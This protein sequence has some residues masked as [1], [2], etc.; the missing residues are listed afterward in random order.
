MPS[1]LEKKESKKRLIV[2]L[3]FCPLEPVKVGKSRDSRMQLLNS[4]DHSNLLR[5]QQ[6]DPNE[7]RPDIVHQVFDLI[8]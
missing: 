5:R 7:A 3:E 6:K 4:D 2:V 8:Y 1:L